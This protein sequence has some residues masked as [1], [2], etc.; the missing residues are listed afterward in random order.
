M[1]KKKLLL[2]GTTGFIGYKFLLFALSNNFL[3]IDILRAKNKKN[4]KIIKLK[5]KYQSQYKNI[6]FDNNN[7]LSKKL[8]NIKV[9]YF[10]NFATLYN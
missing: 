1:K 2:T 7:D 4:N 10:I 6:F 8:K 5:K 3:V 9:D